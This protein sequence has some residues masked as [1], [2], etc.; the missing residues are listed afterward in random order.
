MFS[1][2][3]SGKRKELIKHSFIQL[4]ILITLLRLQV[5]QLSKAE[6]LS[7]GQSIAELLQTS[8]CF[9]Q[10]HG[11]I[12]TALWCLTAKCPEFKST[13]Q[14]WAVCAEFAYSPC[15]CM[16]SHQVF[17]PPPRVQTHACL[18]NSWFYIVSINACLS[19]CVR[20]A[21]CPGSTSPLALWWDR[22][23]PSAI[24]NWISKNKKDGCLSHNLILLLCVI[25]HIF[26]VQFK[27]K[28]FCVSFISLRR[29][30]LFVDVAWPSLRLVVILWVC[31][32]YWVAGDIISI[33]VWLCRQ[34]WSF[35][36]MFQ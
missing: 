33:R 9:I 19:L 12:K 29:V 23:G 32:I 20:L 35:Y 10:S 2:P 13:T 15:A 14:L 26:F 7:N 17:W 30:Y 22:L 21:I 5:T 24:L 16:G 25:I 31:N 8:K 18:A 6:S 34:Y 27:L 3:G 36:G 11:H 4:S 28:H 1:S